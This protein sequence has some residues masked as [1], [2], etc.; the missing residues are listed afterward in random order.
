MGEDITNRGCIH[1]KIIAK[2]IPK[3]LKLSIVTY[4]RLHSEKRLQLLP[5]NQN[6]KQFCADF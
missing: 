6:H 1:E 2:K 4:L 5:L 3:T